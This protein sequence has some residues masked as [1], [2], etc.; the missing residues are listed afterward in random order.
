MFKKMLGVDNDIVYLNKTDNGC[1]VWN[2]NDFTN[3][4][5]NNFI[6][7]IRRILWLK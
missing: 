3:K 6:E 7:I 4:K 1:T 2:E 5:N